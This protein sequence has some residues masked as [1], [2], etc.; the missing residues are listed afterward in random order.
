MQLGDNEKDTLKAP[1][2]GTK[3]NK[4]K[5]SGCCFNCKMMM[6]YHKIPTQQKMYQRQLKRLERQN[7]I[8]LIK[9]SE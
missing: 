5:K 1:L 8:S 4:K 3:T 9:P 7:A 6:C 2:G